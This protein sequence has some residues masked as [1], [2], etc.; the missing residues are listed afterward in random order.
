MGVRRITVALIAAW[1]IGVSGCT[2]LGNVKDELRKGGFAIWYPAEAGIE[3]GQI[4]QIEGAKRIREQKKP[5]TLEA[6]AGEAKFETLKKSV[7][8]SS[9]LDLNFT[10]KILGIAGDM[11][12][13]LKAGTVKSVDLNFGNT[14]IQRITMGDLRDSNVTSKLPA[15]YVEDLRKVRA[16]NLDFVLIGAVVTVAGMKYVF[17]CEDTAQLQAKAPEIAKAI[18]PDFNLKIVSKTEAVWEIPASTP[19]VIGILPVHGKDLNFGI[20]QLQ[21]RAAVK[22]KHIDELK[23]LKSASAKVTFNDL[24]TGPDSLRRASSPSAD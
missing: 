10:N 23:A 18:T 3:A 9:S 6:T 4:W 24:L 5:A 16:G 21:Q 2:T 19:L 1:A 17:K 8:A 13:L 12:V 22:I 11:A 14:S 20:E 7:D 15:G